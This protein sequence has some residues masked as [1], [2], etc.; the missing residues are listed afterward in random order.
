MLDLLRNNMLA[1]ASTSRGFLIDGYP[2]EMEQGVKFE[3]KVF[4]CDI[5]KGQRKL[6]NTREDNEIESEQTITLPTAKGSL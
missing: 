6:F 2:R 3:D 5:V 4:F 1:K